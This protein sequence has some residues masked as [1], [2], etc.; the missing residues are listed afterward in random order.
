MFKNQKYSKTTIYTI[1]IYKWSANVSFL[2]SIKK[3]KKALEFWIEIYWMYILSKNLPSTV[4]N[5]P[6]LVISKEQ[7]F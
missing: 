1:L 3:K 2:S 6:A 7:Q 4:L 5:W